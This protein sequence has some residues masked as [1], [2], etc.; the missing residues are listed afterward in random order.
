MRY[1]SGTHSLTYS[2]THS[3][4]H[5]LTHLLTYSLTH[6]LQVINM[7]A[8]GSMQIVMD[9]VIMFGAINERMRE[10]G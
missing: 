1:P 6:L 10:R 2:P 7:K 9:M 5:L 3:L 8:L 4:T